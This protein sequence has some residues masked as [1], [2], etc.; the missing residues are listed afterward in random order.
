MLLMARAALWGCAVSAGFGGLRLALL[1]PLRGP[2]L[3]PAAGAASVLA[4]L[5]VSTV[6]LCG[7]C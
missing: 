7:C 2:A 4:V 1:L 6:G 5:P 3:P